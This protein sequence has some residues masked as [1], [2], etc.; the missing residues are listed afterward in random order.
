M[1]APVCQFGLSVSVDGDVVLAGGPGAV[2]LLGQYDP[3][4]PNN[5]TGGSCDFNGDGCVDIVDLL[6]LLAHYDP[7]GTGCP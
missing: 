1:M 3:M 4:S 5:C 6:K 7:A 2:A